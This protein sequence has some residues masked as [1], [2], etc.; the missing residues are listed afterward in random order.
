MLALRHPDLF[1][2][3]GDY[4]GLVGP[5]TG[6]GN[7]PGTTVEDLFGGD[8]AAFRAHEPAMLLRANRY[9]ASGGWFE[10]GTA[11]PGALQAQ[12]ELVP[13]ARAAGIATCQ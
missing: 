7:D 3:F 8:E 11:D 10:V 6:D 12:E 9:P 2:T 4:S 5:R 1:G 13:L